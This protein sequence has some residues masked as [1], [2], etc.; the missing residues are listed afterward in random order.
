MLS[1]SE[2]TFLHQNPGAVINGPVINGPD[3][4]AALNTTNLTWTTS[5][6]TSWFVETTNTHDN[7][8]AAQSGSITNNQSSTL[9]TTVT[10]PGTLTFY[11]SSIANDPNGGFDYEFDLDGGYM[12]DIGGDTSWIQDGPFNIP[13]GQHTL[14]WTVSAN[15]DVLDPTQAGFLDQK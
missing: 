5:G 6:N 12:D 3:F 13:A 9:S 14:S 7:V 8:S 4:A 2:V 11:W 10:G 15:G 1:S